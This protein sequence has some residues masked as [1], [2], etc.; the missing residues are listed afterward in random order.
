MRQKGQVWEM[1][2]NKR[3]KWRVIN[4][5]IEMRDWEE[6]FKSGFIRWCRMESGDGREEMRKETRGGRKR[7]RRHKQEKS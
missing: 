4:K 7:R 5:K 6:Y 2:N 3:K 1:V